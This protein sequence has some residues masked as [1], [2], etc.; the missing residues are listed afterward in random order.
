MTSEPP[1]G[2]SD[3]SGALVGAP[4]VSTGGRVGPID[5]SRTPRFA[6]PAT[7]ARLP[8]LDEVERADVV[9]VG[10]P[11]DSGVSYRPGARFG[12]T[13]VRE[14]S[15]LL[16]PFNPAQDVE[17]FATQQVA[18]AGDISINPFDI[19]AG[20]RQIE[21]AATALTRDGA[22]LV[23][24][25]GD[26]T[27]ALP[28]LR[29]ARS[30]AGGPIAVLHFDAHL[31]TWDTYFGAPVTHGTSFRRASEEG[32]LD[33]AACMH[34]GTRGPLYGRGDLAD[35]AA[36][37]FAIVTSDEVGDAGVSATV[38]RIRRR[39]GSRPLYISIDIDVL[40]PAH[41]PGTGTPE[42][43]GL[44]SRELLGIIRGLATSDII[45]ADIV[46]VSPPYDHADI[47]AIAASH[48]AYELISAISVGR[49]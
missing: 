44:T 41:A 15:R 27:I 12:P 43:G 5:A 24:I 46:E 26:H 8:R 11:F 16:R 37:G 10:A 29:A 2:S 3:E 14:A 38:E 40:D 36:S 1:V 4:R 33:L 21:T 34:V 9:V 30:R 6:G 48:V 28:L 45:G 18:D 47:T 13:H 23:V 49:R 39:I 17:P 25:G 19:A 42:A 7:F 32:L 31:D 20:V 22:R 35:D